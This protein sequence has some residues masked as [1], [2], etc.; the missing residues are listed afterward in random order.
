MIRTQSCFELLRIGDINQVETREKIE[1]Q[2]HHGTNIPTEG[3]G[4]EVRETSL[5]VYD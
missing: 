2:G 1:G 3:Y 4:V 5:G